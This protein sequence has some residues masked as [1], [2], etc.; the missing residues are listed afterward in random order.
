MVVDL[1][2]IKSRVFILGAG[3][4]KAANNVM[5]TLGDLSTA[6]RERIGK[7]LP[8]PLEELGNEVELWMTCLSQVQPWFKD[9]HNLENRPCSSGRP[10]LAVALVLCGGRE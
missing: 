10:H 3:F 1:G 5:P 8:K 6:I 7:T 9:Y 4:S 2:A